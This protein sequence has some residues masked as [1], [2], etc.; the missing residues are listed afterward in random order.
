M[1]RLWSPSNNKRNWHPQP[2][3]VLPWLLGATVVFLLWY[4]WQS[5]IPLPNPQDERLILWTIVGVGASVTLLMVW[6]LRLVQISQHSA[7]QVEAINT[8]LT[9][10]IQVRHQTELALQQY[11]E[12]IQDLYNNAPC[13]YH[14]VDANGTVVMLNDTELNMLGYSRYE[15]IDRKKFTEL[16][17]PESIA[18]WLE[19]F[20]LLKQRGWIKD[21][22]FWMQRKDGSTFPVLINATA[23]FDDDGNYAMSRSTLLDLQARKLADQKLQEREAQYR[24]IVEDQT[25][26]ICRFR[27]DGTLTFVNQAYCRYFNQD[28]A[29][30]LNQ[31]FIPLIPP[32]DQTRWTQQLTQLSPDCPMVQSEH[33]VILPSGEIRWQQWTDRAIFDEAGQIIEIQAVGRDIS[34]RR[35]LDRLKD[36]FVSIVSH[37]LRTPLTAIAGALDLLASGKLSLQCEEAK[38]MLTIAASNTDRLVRM[39]NDVLDMERIKSG[40]IAMNRQPCNIEE[41]VQQSIAVM[42]TMAQQAGIQLRVSSM[43][44]MVLADR[45]R[46]IQ[47]LINLLSNAIKFSDRGSTVWIGI[48]RIESANKLLSQ[49]STNYS[50]LDFPALLITVQDEGRGIPEEKQQTIFEPF[51]QIDASDSRQ[52]G[53]TGLGLTI[54]RSILSQHDLPFWLDS[55]I[56]VGS[57][58]SFAISILPRT[59]ENQGGQLE[60]GSLE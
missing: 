7:R 28:A 35:E 29:D 50:P 51:Q 20:E 32:E 38:Q 59:L 10:Q 18:D 52:K 58:F 47:V 40:E 39:I 30:L 21:A 8:K 3:E 19:S 12:A 24:A 53:G 42:Q 45:D 36:E 27:P 41:I 1:P 25:E 44:A 43:S 31:S 16:L 9:Q 46:L 60:G 33:R 48:E 6:A 23:I 26:L 11:I 57:R 34:D 49:D 54:C 4:L 13:G 15:V 14:S 22:E 37:E 5:L 55:A 2:A 56:G 17:A